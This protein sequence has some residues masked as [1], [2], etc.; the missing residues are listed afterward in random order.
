LPRIRARLQRH[1][2]RAG[3]ELVQENHELSA[4][5][6]DDHTHR[7]HVVGCASSSRWLASISSVYTTHRFHADH[8][9]RARRLVDMRAGV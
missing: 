2:W 9:D 1:G 5:T 8:L 4:R 7:G 6:V 3:D